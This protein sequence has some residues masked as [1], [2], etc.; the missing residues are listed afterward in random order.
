MTG[1]EV[2]GNRYKEMVVYM[3]E[4]NRGQA[5]RG[6]SLVSNGDGRRTRMMDEARQKSGSTVKASNFA[7]T[8]VPSITWTVTENP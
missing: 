4:K 1:V 7:A 5:F 8:L 2:Y 6:T 3:V